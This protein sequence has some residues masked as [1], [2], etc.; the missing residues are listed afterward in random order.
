MR[1]STL[2]GKTLRE[3]PAE[4]H[5]ASHRL[6]LRAG[7]VRA[8]E[9]GYFGTLPLGVLS[10]GRLEELAQREILAAGGQEVALPLLAE[11]S[12]RDALV[13]LAGREIDS[14]RQL[15]VVAFRFAPVTIPEPRIRLG[16]F[17]AAQRPSLA[18]DVFH[19]AQAPAAGQRVAQALEHILQAGGVPVTWAEAGP[20]EQGAF[21][22]HSAGDQDLAT[23]G[24]C[25]YAA[26]RSW[27]APAWPEP[28]AETELPPEEVETPGCNTI[29]QLA[30][31]L[32][33]PTAQTL[34]MVFCSVGGKVTCIAIRGDRSV[35]EAKLA[36]VLGTS[37]YYASL[38]EE[39]D[40]I[41]AVGGYASPVGLDPKRVRIVAD[42]SVRSAK[43]LVGGANRPDYHLRN[44]NVPRDFQPGEWADLALV[45]AGDICPRCRSHLAIEP[46]F[47]LA[48]HSL[49]APCRPAAEFLDQEGRS[50]PL[51]QSSWQLDLGRLWAAVVE[52]HHDEHGILWPAACAPLDVHLVG[53]DL[54]VGAVA[55]RAEE[56]Y[57][58]LQAEGYAVLYDDRDA[59]AGVKFNDA[60]L[61]GLPL[62]LT[63][64]KRW[65]QDGLTEAKWRHEADRLKLDDKGLAGELARLRQG[66]DRA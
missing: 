43:N 9:P 37:Q 57:A 31:F 18:V 3:A 19:S 66:R 11:V 28:P 29:A 48:S 36:R 47:A 35:D 65:E 61:I 38:E 7:L 50:R 41:G 14:Y 51:W 16:L 5:L 21:L 20:T 59:S 45:E 33:I 34:K 15:P 42:P 60:D 58:R 30:A 2:M 25:G 40:R 52:L 6:L 56:I 10:L 54:K 22:A 53:L 63:I 39:L 64:S 8:L 55:A 12:P 62:R 4:A 26:L 44:L 23:C 27:A 1:L 13:R 17:G 46:A 49:P 32:N 24:G